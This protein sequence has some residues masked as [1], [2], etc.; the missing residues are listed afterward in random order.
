MIRK[1]FALLFVLVLSAVF[2]N[3]VSPDYDITRV[4]VND[5][6]LTSRILDVERGETA[7]IE[8]T[9]LGI[10]NVDDVRVSAEI[11]GYEYGD[12]RDVSDLFS[13]EAGVTYKRVLRLTAPE[14]IDAS[15]TYTLR[16]E[17]EDD[18]NSETFEVTLN[19]DE[20][21]H[22][23][24]F[25]PLN[26]GIL[27]NPSVVVAGRPVFVTARVENLGEKKEDDILVRASIPALGVS[28]EGFLDE[29]VTELQERSQRFDDDEESSQSVDLLLRIPD[30]AESGEY[31]VKV[32]VIYNRGHSQATQSK[33]I[34]VKGA[35]K[36]GEEETVVNIDGTSRVLGKTEVP[37]KLMIAN[38]GNARATYTVSVEGTGAWG[39]ARVE[40]SFLNLEAGNTGE[41]TVYVR[42]KRD[43]DAGNYNFAVRVNK[44]TELVREIN[45][46]AR[47]E[48]NG[49]AGEGL[50]GALT[51]VFIVL[52][53]V[54][55][56]MVI[57]LAVKRSRDRSP[58]EEP[59]TS[60]QTYYYYP[61][62]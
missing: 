55:V 4:E 41:A 24:A 38:M 9:V 5:E 58:A 39:E 16:I 10:N 30:D 18:R 2:V 11:Q 1:L 7:N 33:K 48:E 32:D 59:V 46:N 8:V 29:L 42:A 45:L 26:G 23:L 43:A 28:T 51:A 15:Q 56:V 34:V 27:V 35:S 49:F 31:E 6:E 44:G 12:I 36:A 25:N 52:L 19:V 3:A 53:A 14:D 20:P 21:R 50:R 40:P 17:V 61:K 47:V 22:N 13:V 57:W 62:Q 54:I 37:Y 60:G